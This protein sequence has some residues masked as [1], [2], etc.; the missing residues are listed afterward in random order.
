MQTVAVK[1]SDIEQAA[2]A[3]DLILKL[4]PALFVAHGVPTSTTETVSRA[5]AE[6]SDGLER[7]MPPSP[8]YFEVQVGFDVLETMLESHREIAAAILLA[9]EL[10][11]APADATEPVRAILRE[12][13]V[14]LR[15]LLA[16]P[17]NP[18]AAVAVA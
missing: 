9:F 1:T 8:V 12:Y 7:L 2:C 3:N 6:Y 14:G 10:A 13:E 17:S 5:L 4:I 11:S 18:G 15:E 16:T